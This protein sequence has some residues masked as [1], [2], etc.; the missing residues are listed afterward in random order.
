MKYLYPTVVV[1]NNESAF[2]FRHSL[3]LAKSR[4][5]W[6]LSGKQ[7]MPPIQ[8]ANALRKRPDFDF[9]PTYGAKI[10]RFATFYSE[11][12]IS[13]FRNPSQSPKQTAVKTD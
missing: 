9:T 7:K 8:S 5:Q 2:N 13:S 12:S 4:D 6:V 1:A 10:G 3:S 11:R